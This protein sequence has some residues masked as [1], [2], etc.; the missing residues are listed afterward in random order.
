MLSFVSL[1]VLALG[2]RAWTV[3]LLK[4]RLADAQDAYAL[5]RLTQVAADEARKVADLAQKMVAAR[6]QELEQLQDAR[7]DPRGHGS[8]T[9][10]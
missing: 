7:N 9:P 8:L 4:E 1:G 6:R 10:G 5:A 2:Q 3:R